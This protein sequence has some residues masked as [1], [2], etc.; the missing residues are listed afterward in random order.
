MGSGSPNMF[1]QQSGAEQIDPLRSEQFRVG[2]YSVEHNA[3]V[4]MQA[5]GVPRHAVE[6]S[7]QTTRLH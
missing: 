6:K 1:T 4:Q 5:G 3:P 7:A 2:H